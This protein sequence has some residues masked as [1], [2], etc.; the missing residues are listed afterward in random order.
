[1]DTLRDIRLGLREQHMIH[2]GTDH[3]KGIRPLAGGVT[4]CAV[5]RVYYCYRC[6]S[7]LVI[8]GS[9]LGTVARTVEWFSTMVTMY[10]V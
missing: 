7:L 5:G 10:N 2:D 6:Q 3:T 1:M 9:T 8:A 4:S